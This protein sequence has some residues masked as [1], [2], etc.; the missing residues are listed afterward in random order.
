MLTGLTEPLPGTTPPRY[1]RE[2]GGLLITNPLDRCLYRSM[3]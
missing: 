2:T 3:S 1:P